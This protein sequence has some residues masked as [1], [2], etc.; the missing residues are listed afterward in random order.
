MAQKIAEQYPRIWDGARATPK[1]AFFGVTATTGLAIIAPAAGGGHPTLINW[2][3]SGKNVVLRGVRLGYKSGNNAPGAFIY[4]VTTGIGD[5]AAT[6]S[7]IATATIVAKQS[8]ALGSGDT[9]SAKV[10][11]SP[12]TNTFTA[13]PTQLCSAGFSL[14]TGVAATAVA[15]FQLR[16]DNPD[17]M[18]TPGTAL[19][20]CYN[21]ATTTA[22]FDVRFDWDEIDIDA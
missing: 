14:F 19:S 16:D 13:A 2:A 3:S 17:I 6:G 8:A 10:Q 22:L 21:A 7:P 5:A 1:R 9:G 12:T 4:A 18:L 15:P 20:L 11:W